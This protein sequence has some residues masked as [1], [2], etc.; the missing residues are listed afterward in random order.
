MKSIKS[1]AVRLSLLA[2]LAL[3]GCG[4]APEPGTGEDQVAGLRS[5]GQEGGPPAGEQGK[6]IT[7]DSAC[8]DCIDSCRK[9]TSMSWMQCHEVCCKPA[10][11][12]F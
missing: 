5:P 2:A 4:V 7:P 10:Y 9:H 8:T 6:A 3:G 1:L 11:V 12:T